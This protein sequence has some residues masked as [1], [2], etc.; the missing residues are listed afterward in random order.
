MALK[1]LGTNKTSKHSGGE[2][3][4]AH[5]ENIG[6]DHILLGAGLLI[7]CYTDWRYGKIY[8]WITFP[9]I[10]AGFIFVTVDGEKAALLLYMRSIG[11][12]V[13]FSLLAV[14]GMCNFGAGDAK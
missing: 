6:F 14:A 8:N 10:I 13:I 5:V 4:T 7:S 2:N 12:G 11:A 1:Y 9:L 3:I